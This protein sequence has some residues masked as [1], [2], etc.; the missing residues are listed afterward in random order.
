MTS[1]QRRPYEDTTVAADKSKAEIRALLVRYGVEQY[2]IMEDAAQAIIS[3]K[4][5]G[6]VIRIEVPLPPLPVIRD[7]WSKAEQQQV[8]RGWE[9][10]E[11]RIWRVAL[12]W[13]K[14]QLEA[15]ESGFR[16]FEQVFLADT[17]VRPGQTFSQWA[18][19]QIDELLKT[20]R[21]PPLT[22]SLPSGGKQTPGG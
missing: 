2:G 9:Q 3:F 20:G 14:N 21:L 16:T 4:R 10:E 17:V 22:L 6:R 5:Q 13:I 8:R 1:K 11:R 15:V 18:E 19:P 12:N 7:W